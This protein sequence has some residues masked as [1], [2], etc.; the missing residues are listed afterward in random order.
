[1]EKNKLEFVSFGDALYFYFERKYR[2]SKLYRGSIKTYG[3]LSML[4]SMLAITALDYHPVGVLLW[5]VGII[6]GFFV[7]NLVFL[8]FDIAPKMFKLTPNFEREVM[9]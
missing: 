8:V 9:L 1:M 7:L 3:Y 2:R 4:V 5:I 6:A